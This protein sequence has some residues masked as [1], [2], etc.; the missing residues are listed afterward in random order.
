MQISIGTGPWSGAY[1]P[2]GEAL[3]K[4][5]NKHLLLAIVGLATAPFGCAGS[6]SSPGSATTSRGVPRRQSSQDRRGQPCHGVSGPDPE[7]GF[8]EGE[9]LRGDSGLDARHHQGRDVSGPEP[10]SP[11]SG[12]A[13]GVLAH[14]QTESA[15]IYRIVKTIILDQ[16]ILHYGRFTRP[17]QLVIST[18]G[19]LHTT[20]RM[21][22]SRPA[23]SPTW[24]LSRQRRLPARRASTRFIFE[25]A[26]T[27]AGS[28][29]GLSE[30]RP[31][32]VMGGGQ[33]D[34][35]HVF[36]LNAFDHEDP[37]RFRR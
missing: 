37:H 20:R 18:A 9:T 5:L 16:K 1:F 29:R 36:L 27:W 6:A 7:P 25:R 30:V 2:V 28:V 35:R 33:V 13:H 22:A 15:V 10:G 26:R 19:L 32:R 31:V 3:A 14:R 24:R 34:R 21:L 4:V 23:A 11:R 12:D 8:H 17:T